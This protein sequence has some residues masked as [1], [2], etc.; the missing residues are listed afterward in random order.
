MNNETSLSQSEIKAIEKSIGYIFNDNEHL[1]RAFMHSSMANEI[2]CESNERYEFFGDAIL[3]FIVSEFLVRHS[4]KLEGD[5]SIIRA[6]LVSAKSLS[7]IITDLQI[8]QYLIVNK[9]IASAGAISDNI[10]CD[11]YES[12]LAG[13]Y[14]DGGMQPAHDFVYKTLQLDL[15]DIEQLFEHKQDYKTPLQEY[16][17][18]FGQVEIEYRVVSEIGPAHSPIFHIAL[19]I[20]GEFKCE[21]KGTNKKNAEQQCA[22]SLYIQLGLDKK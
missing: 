18:S 15:I 17:Q 1:Q 7:K 20:N 2:N 22:K 6:S 12:L 3:D 13:I 8:Y 10:K 19:Y 14:F 16:L 21:A 4:K 5:L 9:S 11:L